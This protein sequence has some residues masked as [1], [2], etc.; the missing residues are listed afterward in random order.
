MGEVPSNHI[1][2]TQGTPLVHGPGLWDRGHGTPLG[3]RGAVLVTGTPEC[4]RQG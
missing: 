2:D 3:H 1:R 4:E